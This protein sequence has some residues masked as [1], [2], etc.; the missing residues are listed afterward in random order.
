MTGERWKCWGELSPLL[1]A[2]FVL[3]EQLPGTSKVDGKSWNTPAL[4]TPRKTANSSGNGSTLLSL[5]EVTEPTRTKK[6]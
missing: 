1:K 2:L 5:F 6:Y 3:C 4:L